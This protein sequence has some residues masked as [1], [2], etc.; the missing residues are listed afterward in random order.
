MS[1]LPVPLSP[2]IM[3]VASLSATFSTILKTRTISSREPMMTFSSCPFLSSRLRYWFSLR[4]RRISMALR[5]TSL[6]SSFL[7]FLMRYW[8]APRFTAS[9]ADCWDAYAVM[10]T[11]GSVGSIFLIPASSW[12]PSIPGMRMS[13]MT[14]S[15][16]LAADLLQRLLAV[17][18]GRDLVAF[19][20]QHDAQELGH[21]LLVVDDQDLLCGHVAL[22]PN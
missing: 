1:S 8:N 19:L 22:P 17:V 15:K 10:I 16:L 2:W 3:M 6:I 14:T 13:V 12:M 7:A 20:P 9:I 21:A 11:T 5:T 18:H 4:T